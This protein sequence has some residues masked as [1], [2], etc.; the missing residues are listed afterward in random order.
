MVVGV[1][2]GVGR[3]VGGMC[4]PA[5]WGEVYRRGNPPLILV[6]EV[7]RRGNPSYTVVFRR[8]REICIDLAERS[9]MS[10]RSGV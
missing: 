7:Y 1:V 3:Y 6:G 2:G 5:L 4:P 8:V 9:E 10:V